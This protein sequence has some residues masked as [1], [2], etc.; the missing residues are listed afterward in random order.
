MEGKSD[1]LESTK[2]NLFDTSTW[3]PFCGVTL[4][5]RQ[6][7]QLDGGIFEPDVLLLCF[8]FEK[9]PVGDIDRELARVEQGIFLL[10]LYKCALE[11]HFVEKG[12]IYVSDP[13]GGIEIF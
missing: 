12:K 5:L 6:A 13:D 4:T 11:V 7:L 2:S 3:G 8:V 9:K 10:V 1:H